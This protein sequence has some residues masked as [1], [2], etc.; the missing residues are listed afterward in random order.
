M[1]FER[2]GEIVF[3][4]LGT[5]VT[6]RAARGLTRLMQQEINNG[7]WKQNWPGDKPG[8]PTPE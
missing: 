8:Q 6:E 7:T 3:K 5:E 2:E 4:V 1:V